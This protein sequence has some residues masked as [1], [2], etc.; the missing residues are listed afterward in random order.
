MCLSISSSL[1]VT[2]ITHS[3]KQEPK[4]FSLSFLSLSRSLTRGNTHTHTHKRQ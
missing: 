2:F 4:I 1:H 3:L